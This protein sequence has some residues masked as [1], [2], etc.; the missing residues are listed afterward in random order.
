MEEFALSF[1]TIV[2]DKGKGEKEGRKI[3]KCHLTCKFRK[4]K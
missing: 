3:L 2:L 4:E 1:N